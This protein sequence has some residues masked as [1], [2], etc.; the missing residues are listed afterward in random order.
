MI[1]ADARGFRTAG[2]I[3]VAAAT[4][5]LATMLAPFRGGEA[6]ILAA[7]A[8]AAAAFVGMR[9]TVP[10]AASL[11]FALAVVYSGTG[12]AWNLFHRVEPFDEIAHVVTGFA[13]TP[14]LAFIVLGPWLRDWRAQL[15][16]LAVLTV[17]LGVAAGA[18]W[19]GAE[20]ILREL[21]SREAVTVGL[22][23]AITDMILGGF[24]SAGSLPMLYWGV[25]SRELAPP[26][27]SARAQRSNATRNPR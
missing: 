11:A 12:W 21:T 23:D 2:W 14:I 19:E 16:R 20:W 13:L 4:A 9:R 7:F 5:L 8:L 6:A 25:R 24:G 1:S 27:S 17:S 22:S 3:A 26:D 15:L 10:A 18:V